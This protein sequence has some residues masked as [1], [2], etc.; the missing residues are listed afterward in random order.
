LFYKKYIYATRLRQ[1]EGNILQ[2]YNNLLPTSN[3]EYKLLLKIT[4]ELLFKNLDVDIT[5]ISKFDYKT[6]K[7]DPLMRVNYCLKIII[8]DKLIIQYI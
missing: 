6:D 4:S 3:K 1:I 2:I 8:Q 7:L 5:K